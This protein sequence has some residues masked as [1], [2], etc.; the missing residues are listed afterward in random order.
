MADHSD[1]ERIPG[2]PRYRTPKGLKTDGTEPF[3]PNFLLKEWIAGSVLLVGYFIWI[4]FNPVGLEE[5][6]NPADTSFLPVPDWYFLFLYQLLKYIPGQAIWLGTVVV[7]GL[8]VTL[9]LFVPFLDRKKSRHPY[10]RIIPTSAM[11]L[12]LIFMGWLTYEA[13][14]QHEAALAKNPHKPKAPVAKDT[15]LV[16]PNHP[17]AKTFSSNCAACHG[18]DLKG[19]IGPSLLGVGNKY[20]AQQIEEIIA[21]GK[22]AGMPAGVVQGDDAKKVADWLS[23]QKQ[24]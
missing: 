18:A 8:A 22:P 19:Q 4:M 17:G 20:N 11:V 24:K 5:V 10:K 6:A 16:E 12:S 23:K 1:K 3:F 21:K 2:V 9:L 13:E 15:A 7:P 14:A